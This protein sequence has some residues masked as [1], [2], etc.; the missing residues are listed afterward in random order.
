MEETPFLT[1]QGEGL[2]KGLGL[3]WKKVRVQ[4]EKDGVRYT[5]VSK[6]ERAKHTPELNLQ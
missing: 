2:L 6:L 3:R 5:S 1:E 4:A